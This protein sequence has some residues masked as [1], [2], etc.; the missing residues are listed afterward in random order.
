METKAKFVLMGFFT[1]AVVA[2]V[3]WFVY[4]MQNTGGFRERAVYRVRFE[5]SVGGLITGSAVQ[6]NGI[7]VG[8][9]TDLT[10]NPENPVEVTATIAIDR[11]TPVRADTRVG[12]DYKGLTGVPTISL[13][14]GNRA[15]PALVP[16]RGQ[17]PMLSADPSSTQDMTS[18]AREVLRRLDTI[19]SDNA[20]PLHNT[21]KNLST[22][23]DAL[24]RNSDHVDG[25]ISGLER[26][27]GGGPAKPA[28]Q[29]YDLVAPNKFPPADKPAHGQL[30]VPEP[31]AKLLQAK[32]IQSFE[33]AN[34]LGAVA[35]P[36]DGLTAQ[37]QLLIDIRSFQIATAPEPTA[38]VEFTAKVLADTGAIIGARTF[39]ATAAAPALNTIDASAA[40]AALNEAFNK[41]ATE[42]VVWTNGVI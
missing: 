10:L 22:F 18:A 15:L 17:P 21:I 36:M 27:T 14:G 33:N 35:R 37:F 1:L 24:A 34:Y 5:N 25:I 23:S 30:V 39:H 12:L 29:L 16:V 31:T 40:A 4:W 20:D 38:D 7:R 8:D 42:L 3:F 32:V 41:A 19:L 28:P 13:I 26:M 2:G 11:S 6:F 9:V